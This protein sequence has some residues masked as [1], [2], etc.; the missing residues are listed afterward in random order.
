MQQGRHFFLGSFAAICLAGSIT[1]TAIAEERNSPDLAETIS[2]V[3]ENVATLHKKLPDFICREDVTVRENEKAKTTEKKHYQLS[4]RAVRQP[5]VAAN[6]FLESRDII[7]ATVDGK[8]VKENKYD[9]PVYFLRGGFAQDLFTFFDEPTSSCY[10]FKPVSTPGTTDQNILVIDANLN[11]NLRPLPAE[12]A[13]IHPQLS[14]ARVWIDLKDFEVVRIQEQMSHSRQFS[15]PFSRINGD[16]SFSPVIEYAPVSIHGSDYWLPRTKSVEFIKSK[17]QF[18]ITY[19][20]QYSDYH[21]FETSATIT[22]IPD[23]N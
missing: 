14:A 4:L 12:C 5:Q 3:R 10:E 16:Y 20:S 21:K 1:V 8:A 2:K 13:H 7:S 17:G 15:V 23:A 18:S 11:K 9:P 22:T 6:S 19:T